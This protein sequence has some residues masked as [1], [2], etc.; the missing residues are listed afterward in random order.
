MA[1][2]AP[3]ISNA[4]YA[5]RVQ[6]LLRGDVLLAGAI[7]AI[8]GLLILPTPRW[9]LDI[10]LA[11][12]VTFS[13]MVLMTA[14]FTRKALEFSTFP[15]ILLIATMFRLGLNIASTRLILS[16]GH[17][18]PDAAGSVIEA[19][20]GFVMQ[21]NYVIGMIVFS[22][23]VIVNFVVITRG[24]GRIAEVAARFSLDAMPGKQMAI[25]ADL[26]AGLITEDEARTRRKT[27]EDESNFFGAMDGASKFVRG[28]AIAG[29]LIT[30]INI[31]GGII[32]GVM[33]MNMSLSDA[34][35]SYTLL[36]IGD[37]LVSQIPAL[38]VSVAAGL[39]V[40]K[41]GADGAADKL[42]ATQFA[43]Y[44]KALAMVAGVLVLLAV[45]PGMPFAP[46]LLLAAGV[47][48][49]AWGIRRQKSAAAAR[50][51]ADDKAK[52]PVVEDDPAHMLA[53][54]DLRIELGY[55]L[56]PLIHTD[57]GPRLTDQVKALRR[58][59]A[60]D[61]GFVTPPVRILDNMQLGANDYVIRLKEQEVTRGV[62]KPEH[63]LV[64]DPAGGRIGL[65][66]EPTKEP[67]FGLDAMWIDDT[68]RE[69]AS[70]KGLTVVDAA[71]VLTTHLTEIIKSEAPEL[72]SYAETKK[73]IDGLPGKHRNLV[74]DLIPSIATV[75]TV[76]RVLQGL[77]AEKISI[78]DLPTILEAIAEA[79]P[80]SKSAGQL[81][82]MVRARLARQICSALKGPDG[83][84]AIVTLSAA[85]E[86]EFGDALI[87]ENGDRQLAMAPSKLQEFVTQA[88]GQLEKA[89]QEGDSAAIVTSA[90][91]RPFVRSVIERVRPQT[92]VLS[93][94]EIH[95]HTRLKNLGQI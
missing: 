79:A 85:W 90:G 74:S 63:Y 86:N 12:S 95:P 60:Q 37:G 52:A 11:S 40:S 73:L 80:Q 30:L 13:V 66:G 25:D 61:L 77:L 3:S 94:N 41:A 38:I 39:L 72:L 48:A 87:G 81:V 24:S 2:A 78:R 68:Q 18:G 16:K 32:I 1:T 91:L 71:T 22:I 69:E 27:L 58:S 54:D 43:A 28:D 62:L 59:I 49:A 17:E 84:A 34:G 31:I 44:P 29:L 10:L 65:I 7:I 26:S 70:L 56:L 4:N 83:A 14:L 51:T 64:M 55:G 6:K 93:Q 47:G 5:S 53:I 15:S 57:K 8:L 35:A 50:K 33:Q 36:T 45:M 42:L 89:A 92:L 23:L 21:G 9:L 67:A 46:F 19:F 88:L 76:Q 20:G 82:E 75:T